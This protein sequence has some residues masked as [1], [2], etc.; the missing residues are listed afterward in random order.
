L[1][2]LSVEVID[3][4]EEPFGKLQFRNWWQR[5]TIVMGR[6]EADLFWMT[7]ICV[8]GHGFRTAV[9]VVLIAVEGRIINEGNR[10]IGVAGTGSGAD[11]AIVMRAS[12]FSYVVGGDPHRRLKIEEILAMPMER[13][14]VGYG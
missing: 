3:S 10:V 11:S 1:E 14:W 12:H 2:E 5:E 13:V 4:I 9:E 7:L 8:G 6:P